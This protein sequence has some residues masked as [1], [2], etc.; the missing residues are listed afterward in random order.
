MKEILQNSWICSKISLFAKKVAKKWEE[1][2]IGWLV[3]RNFD[4]FK[5]K[6]SFVYKIAT[7][8]LQK[9]QGLQFC[10][11]I[12]DSVILNAFTHYE[13]GVYT[14][15]FL[16]PFLPTVVCALI[17]A[18][19]IASYLANAVIKKEVK[20]SVGSLSVSLLLL[21][22]LFFISSVTSYARTDSIKIFALYFVFVLS[23][24][25]VINCASDGK[26][27]KLML[28]LFVN[29]GIVVSIY[30]IYQ[31]FFGDNIGHAWI[32]EDMF[33]DISVRVYSTFGNPNVLGEYLL[34]LI[35]IC[36]GLIYASRKWQSKLFYLVALALSG[37]CMVL[38]QSR[39][40]WLGLILVAFIFA[41][42]IDRRLLLLGA[43]GLLAMPFVLPQS[44]I[45]RFTSIGN[46]TDSSTSYRVHIWLGTLKMLRS[47]WWNGI[48]IGT[49]A[50]NKV[51]PIFAYNATPALHSHNLYL[52]LVSESG[53]AGIVAYF[54]CTLISLK[55][56]LVGYLCGKKSIY[57][58]VC[59]CI[60]AGI[61]GFMLQGMFDY[62][63]YNYRVFAIFFV[64]CGVGIGAYSCSCKNKDIT[65]TQQKGVE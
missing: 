8:I 7:N 26:R 13:Y 19:T 2:N 5:T 47:F 60:I 4:D 50:F 63:W 3:T 11:K 23:I 56:M 12:K 57:G 59:G 34:L 48:G 6:N 37:V 33:S 32:D 20:L 44:I 64:Y 30:G 42:L 24:F 16:A 31:Y 18:A 14:I 25:P 1:S 17:A 28:G 65:M 21:L 62:S 52:Q 45:N 58:I 10:S 39:G 27:L 46:L 15:L 55:K 9:L 41:V 43:A 36:G 61:F 40:C 29:S 53:I 49:E 38:T 54:G 51:Y 35:P 22:V